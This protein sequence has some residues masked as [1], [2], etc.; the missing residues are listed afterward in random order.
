MGTGQSIEKRVSEGSGMKKIP[1]PCTRDAALHTMGKTLGKGDL[2]AR[3]S[4]FPAVQDI[5]LGRRWDSESNRG[6]S[7]VES[8]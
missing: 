8:V 4:D 1:P 5:Q 7:A 2:Q 6:T 3:S